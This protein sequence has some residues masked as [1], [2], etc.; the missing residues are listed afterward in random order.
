MSFK[1]TGGAICSPK[2]Y[3]F[4]FLIPKGHRM[5]A[6]SH[7]ETQS[8]FGETKEDVERFL[9][10]RF[11]PKPQSVPK[12]VKEPFLWF[13]RGLIPAEFP[14]RARHLWELTRELA[15]DE[16]LSLL[17]SCAG[18]PW[19]RVVF[20]FENVAGPTM[21]GVT[22]RRPEGFTKGFREHAMSKEVALR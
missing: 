22:L 3:A 4:H 11:R 18:D 10:R 15:G 14:K 12:I 1:A 21:A 19:R 17:M 5:I 13:S 16:A 8:V 6:C 7:G 9:K 2:G 20:G